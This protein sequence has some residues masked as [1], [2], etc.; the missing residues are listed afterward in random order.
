MTDDFDEPDRSEPVL[1]RLHGLGQTYW[2]DRPDFIAIDGQDVAPQS[3]SQR[4]P[5]GAAS[6]FGLCHHLPPAMSG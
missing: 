6:H 3:R 4:R 5:V 1:G 2:P